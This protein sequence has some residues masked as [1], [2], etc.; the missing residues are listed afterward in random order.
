MTGSD[1]IIPRCLQYTQDNVA[2]YITHESYIIKGLL[3]GHRHA[4]TLSVSRS[5]ALL[6]SIRILMYDTVDFSTNV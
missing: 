5:I 1:Y 4:H 2:Q 6:Y 3:L